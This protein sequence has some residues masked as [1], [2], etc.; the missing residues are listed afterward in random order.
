MDDELATCCRV[1]MRLPGGSR[2]TRDW[3]LR[4]TDIDENAHNRTLWNKTSDHPRRHASCRLCRDGGCGVKRRGLGIITGLTQRT[5][6]DLAREIAR[7]HEMTDEP[8]G[9]N[10]T[11]LPSFAKPPYAEYLRAIVE[12]GV[13]IVETAGRNPEQY[14]P[15]QGERRQGHP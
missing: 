9:V 15:P 7:C 3:P 1:T 5:P 14:L 4:R 6:K 2:V 12:G 8:F 10:L 11:F 13:R